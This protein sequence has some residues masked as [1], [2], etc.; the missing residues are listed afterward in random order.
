MYQ[1]QARSF[2]YQCTYKIWINSIKEFSR[3]WT[4]TKNYDRRTNKPAQEQTEGGTDGMTDNPNPIYSPTFSK[5][6]Y[7]NDGWTNGQT[8]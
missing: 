1:S 6:G 5:R 4:E 7:N 2:Q 8:E 3:Y